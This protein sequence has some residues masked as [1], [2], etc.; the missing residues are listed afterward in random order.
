MNLKLN[1]IT[2]SVLFLLMLF[3]SSVLAQAR[4]DVT[5]KNFRDQNIAIQ[6]KQVKLN[7]DVDWAEIGTIT[8]KHARTFSNITIGSLLRAVPQGGGKTIKEFRVEDGKTDY[9]VN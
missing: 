4:T 6:I 3:A 8:R 9:R 7:G 1:Y 2:L 5:I